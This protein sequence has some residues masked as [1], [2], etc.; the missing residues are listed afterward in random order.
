MARG[1]VGTSAC[2]VKREIGAADAVLGVLIGVFEVEEEGGSYPVGG[3]EGKDCGEGD[4][5]GEEV[6]FCGM[7]RGEKGKKEMG[8]CFVVVESV[9]LWTEERFVDWR[10]SCMHTPRNLP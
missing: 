1:A 6:H 5:D 9:E 10:A 8:F 3:C 4:E 2:S 7:V